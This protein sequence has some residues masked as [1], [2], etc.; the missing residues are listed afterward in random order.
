MRIR[1]AIRSGTEEEIETLT[2]A[3]GK[4]AFYSGLGNTTPEQALGARKLVFP[5]PER[6]QL[7]PTIKQV[8]AEHATP[9]CE[10]TTN[11]L[12]A[13][14]KRHPA[15]TTTSVKSIIGPSRST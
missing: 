4:E 7:S 6:V 11:T 13:E 9:Y 12:H 5:E 10:F 3:L 2:R 8:D 1:E 14:P 15:C